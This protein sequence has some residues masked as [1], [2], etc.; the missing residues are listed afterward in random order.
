MAEFSPMT[1]Y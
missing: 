1:Y